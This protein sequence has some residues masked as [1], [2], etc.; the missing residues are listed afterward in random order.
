MFVTVGVVCLS[1][2]IVILSWQL[3]WAWG[4]AKQFP[5]QTKRLYND[6]ELPRV[7]VLL[8]I[9]GADPSL[10]GCLRGLLNQDYPHYEIRIIIDSLKD[11]A[12]TLV[13]GILGADCG[14]DFKSV[15]QRPCVQV[16]PLQKRRKTCGLKSSALLQAIDTLDESCQVVALIDADVIPY[17]NWLR[18]LVQ[19]LADAQVGAATGIRWFMPDAPT[20]GSL[21]RYL[22]N[23]AAVVQ[24]H[25]LHIPWGGSLALRAE[26]LGVGR[27]S[28]PSCR[29]SDL[30]EK[31]GVSLWE[32]TGSYRTIRDLGLQLAFVPAATMIN[33]ETTDLRGCFGF[34]RRQMLNVRLYHGGWPAILVH[35]LTS[36]FALFVALALTPIAVAAGSPTA[37][38][39]LLAGPALYALAMGIGLAWIEWHIRRLARERGAVA[40]RRFFKTVLAFPLVHVVYF[41]CLA[42]ASMLGKVSW[43]GITYDVSGPWAVR[44]RRYRPYR[45]KETRDQ[46][47]S[48]V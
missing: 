25:A 14:T 35:G 1:V 46:C 16:S 30:I 13:Q 21:V 39:L 5:P 26:L 23:A 19:P 12:W 7:V 42:S 6:E 47:A 36:S 37:A 29:H 2:L 43:R 11:P 22:W 33:R 40:G 32:D 17:P 38:A 20:W 44:M 3:I 31:W 10:A 9:R 4:F 41:A 15:L 24:M 8:P 34:I 48:V 27:V 45:T 18:D 28:N